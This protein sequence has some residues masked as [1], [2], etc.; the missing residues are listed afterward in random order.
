MLKRKCSQYDTTCSYKNLLSMSMA[1]LEP[2]L[3]GN[4]SISQMGKWKS[5][6]KSNNSMPSAAGK[7]SRFSEVRYQNVRFFAAI[8]RSKHLLLKQGDQIQQWLFPTHQKEERQSIRYPIPK[9]LRSTLQKVMMVMSHAMMGVL[10]PS[11]HW[12][13]GPTFRI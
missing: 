9:G 13:R 10:L 11:T 1:N 3:H 8:L 5:K 7:S 2:P 12:I 6:W 4:G